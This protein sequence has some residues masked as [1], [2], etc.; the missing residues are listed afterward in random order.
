MGGVEKVV[1]QAPVDD[2]K[3]PVGKYLA[4]QSTPST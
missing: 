1:T 3:L 4:Q 2:A